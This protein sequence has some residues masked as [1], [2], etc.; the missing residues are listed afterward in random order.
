MCINHPNTR[1]DLLLVEVV[2]DNT[3]GQLL[4][5][6]TQN[7][8]DLLQCYPGKVKAPWALQFSNEQVSKVWEFCLFNCEN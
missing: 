2:G 4:L 8:A 3:V 5:C 6:A 1:S 7:Y